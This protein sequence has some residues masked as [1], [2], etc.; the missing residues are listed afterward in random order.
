MILNPDIQTKA[1]AEI[2]QVLGNG[3][4]PDFSDLDSLPY[5]TAIM[6]EVLR[7][8][9]HIHFLFTLPSHFSL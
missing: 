9:C 2:D 8:V 1:Q 6:K 4:L 7:Y 3:R 5:V